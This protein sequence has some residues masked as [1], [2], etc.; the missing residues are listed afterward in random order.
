MSWT[1]FTYGPLKIV[2]HE[3]RFIKLGDKVIQLG[4]RKYRTLICLMAALGGWVT[5]NYIGRQKFS[6]NVRLQICLLRKILE[7]TSL[8]IESG[9]YGYYRLIFDEPS[10]L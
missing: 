10:I 4:E 6:R 7:G 2:H 3:A 5:K 8:R 1:G 9:E